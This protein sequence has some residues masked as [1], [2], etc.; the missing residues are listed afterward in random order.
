MSR[1]IIVEAAFWF[2]LGVILYTLVGYP[3]LTLVL[4]AIV[5][6]RVDKQP[7]TPRVSLIIAAYNEEAVIADKIQRSL[8]LDYPIDRLEIIVASDGSTDRTDD[9]VRSFAGR[10]V[11]LFRHEGRGGKTQTL[12]AAVPTAT[13]DIVV[14]SD[15]TG[16]YNPEAIRELAANFN[17]PTVGCVTGRVA[18]RYGDDATSQG[19]KG[20]QRIAVAIRRAE[21]RFGS[22]T[23]V[24]GSIHAIRRS[25][26]RPA[27]PAFSLDVIDAV[28]TVVQGRRV[29]YENNAVSL[30]QS[31]SSPWD[32]FRCRVRI[33]VRTTSMIPYLLTQL[34]KHRR[35]G[36]AFQM[37]SHKI[38]RWWL[39]LLLALALAS[40]LALIGHARIYIIL[41]VLQVAA[42]ASAIAGLLAGRLRVRVPGISMLALFLLGNIALC[43]GSFK[44]MLGKR[45]GAWEPVR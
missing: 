41:A 16:I 42:Y 25:L 38:L 5:R 17:D 36:Y 9:I 28:H 8:E 40:N 1:L 22:Q 32:E 26:Y 21:S 14:F 27:N 30:E 44:A 20:Y 6:R 19:F 15:A 2:S 7:I 29:V 10:G 18:Y 34:L 24:S 45:M 37:I 23:S 35:V 33:S 12:N 3:L 11:K 13:G 31:R 43:V 4:A 39:W